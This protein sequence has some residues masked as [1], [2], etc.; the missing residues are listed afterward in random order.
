L[1][2]IVLD[3]GYQRFSRD[4]SDTSD[5]IPKFISYKE[6]GPGIA[7]SR[8]RGIAVVLPI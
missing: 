2:C 1:E 4:T 3:E 7:V 5:A 6:S 8:Y